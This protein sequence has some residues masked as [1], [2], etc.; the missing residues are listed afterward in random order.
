MT[1]ILFFIEH[2][3]REFDA[4]AVIKRH[5]DTRHGLSTIVAAVDQRAEPAIANV[6]PQMV[7]LPW[8]RNA[9]KWSV[10]RSIVNAY[11]QAIFFDMCW[12]QFLLSHVVEAKAPRGRFAMERVL[13]H[14]WGPF[15]TEYLKQQGIPAERIFENG[16]P[17]YTLY[18]ERYRG[19]YA[20]RAELAARHNLDP[21]KPWVLFPENYGWSFLSEAQIRK[22]FVRKGLPEERAFEN[23]RFQIESRREAFKWFSG[24][25]GPIEFILR[26]RPAITAA[27]YQAA[28]E[29]EGIVPGK[30]VRI[31]KHGPVR[32]WI[33]AAD[34]VISSFSTTLLEAAV[35]GKPAFAIEPVPFVADIGD[36]EWVQQLDR[37]TSRQAF[38]DLV[39]DPRSVPSTRRS[40]DFAR[41]IAHRCEDAL[42]G[43]AD[44][45]NNILESQRSVQIEP[46]VIPE[47]PLE[48][49]KRFRGRAREWL[50]LPMRTKA[51]ETAKSERLSDAEVA[52][53]TA[54]VNA[55]FAREK[56]P[57]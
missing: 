16:N 50:G 56:L 53:R 34:M 49:F 14:T 1:D 15:R 31:I 47:P 33:H 37:V 19:L 48:K 52:S 36:V 55:L 13:H 4:A 9:E 25:N 42:I 10:L 35:A 18:L 21:N 45:I 43:A 8:A 11:P 26:P 5:L 41:G 38:E 17:L 27:A 6:R 54:Q 51:F 7:V 12:E 24:V 32:E 46:Y 23:R 44:I 22:R 3:V 39:R 2:R 40:A 29:S 28:F 20:T 30:S 57:A